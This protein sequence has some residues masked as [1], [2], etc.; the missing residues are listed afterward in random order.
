MPGFDFPEAAL[1][2][3]FLAASGLKPLRQGQ[4]RRQLD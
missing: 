1:S 3:T 2:E 4:A